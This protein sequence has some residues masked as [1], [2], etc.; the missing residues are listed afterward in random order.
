[1][2]DRSKAVMVSV[3]IGSLSETLFESELF[4]HVRGA[5]TDAHE[6]RQGK[7]EIADGG[8]LF[9]DEIGNLPLHLQS[10]LLAA[11]EN[12]TITRIGSN[13]PVKNRYQVNLRDK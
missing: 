9:L 5:F 11:I 2:S 3:D 7:F 10:K 12:R 1:M 4:G 6:S 8:T 13:Q